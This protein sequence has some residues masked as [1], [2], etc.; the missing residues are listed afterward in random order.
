MSHNDLRGYLR[1]LPFVPFT[2]VT[3]DG[4]RYP[5][6]NPELVVPGLSSVFIGLAPDPETPAY[7]RH[8]FL[9]LLHV[10]RLEAQEP[11]PLATADGQH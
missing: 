8:V 2:I 9:S 7:E 11:P 1:R 10:Q 4:T 5:I 3:T 6:R